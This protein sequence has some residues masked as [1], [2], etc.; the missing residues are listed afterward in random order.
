MTADVAFVLCIR[1]TRIYTNFTPHTCVL[2]EKGGRSVVFVCLIPFITSAEVGA[3]HFRAIASVIHYSHHHVTCMHCSRL[4]TSCMMLVGRCSTSGSL[5]A[6]TS[7]S[8]T[9]TRASSTCGRHDGVHAG[10]S[11]CSSAAMALPKDCGSGLV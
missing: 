10:P 1:S 2:S 6:L 3:S 8:L 7:K 5:R 4:V 9:V 11:R